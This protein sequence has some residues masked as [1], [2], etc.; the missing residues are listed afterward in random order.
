MKQLLLVWET[1]P[2][3]IQYAV[4]DIDNP[5]CTLIRK[6]NKKF[7]GLENTKEE[8]SDLENLC[9]ALT[10]IVFVSNPTNLGTNLNIVEVHHSGVIL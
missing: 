9:E 2:E 6:C 10:N 3:S 7:I 1:N 5:I 4:F 8:D